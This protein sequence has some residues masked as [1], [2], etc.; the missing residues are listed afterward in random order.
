MTCGFDYQQFLRFSRLS[1]KDFDSLHDFWGFACCVASGVLGTGMVS[2]V[3][4]WLLRFQVLAWPPVE[5]ESTARV[6][7]GDMELRLWAQLGGL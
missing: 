2:G 6:V 1:L 7:A 5:L 4:I 3:P